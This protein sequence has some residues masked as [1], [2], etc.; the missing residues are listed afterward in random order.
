M[1]EQVPTEEGAHTTAFDQLR[2]RLYVFL[3]RICRVAV[4][5]EES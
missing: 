3:P 1:V 4:Y 5:V 2:Q